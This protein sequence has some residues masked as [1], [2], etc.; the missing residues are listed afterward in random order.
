MKNDFSFPP[1]LRLNKPEEF[2]RVFAN[3]L[4]T[5]DKFFTILAIQNEKGHARLG[6]A[7]AKK[8][9]KRAVDRNKI[10]RSARESFRLN[11]HQLGNW[12]IVVLARHDAAQ[13]PKKILTLSL[14]KHWLK[15][16]Q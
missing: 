9:I 1:Q 4:K 13:V 14:S 7:I 5:T 11:Q 10:K 2:Q 16:T 12:D 8:N 15:L 3:P 6:L